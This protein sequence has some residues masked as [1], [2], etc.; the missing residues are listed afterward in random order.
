[1]NDKCLSTHSVKRWAS[2]RDTNHSWSLALVPWADVAWSTEF[3]LKINFYRMKKANIA[4][5]EI[6]FLPV[7]LIATQ[8]ESPRE[9]A[10][11]W[12]KHVSLL[13]M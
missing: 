5:E 9:E 10:L 2:P 6:N 4:G 3:H 13:R 1:M 11:K 12:H 7:N 8:S